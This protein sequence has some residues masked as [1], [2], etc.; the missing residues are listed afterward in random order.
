[1]QPVLD[2][3]SSQ[4]RTDEEYVEQRIQPLLTRLKETLTDMLSL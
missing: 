2:A 3:I 1:M 4:I